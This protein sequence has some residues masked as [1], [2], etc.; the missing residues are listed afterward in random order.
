MPCTQAGMHTYHARSTGN[1][2]MDT[3]SK[4]V[5]QAT[6]CGRK[7]LRPTRGENKTQQTE[8]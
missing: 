7:Q 1:I 6:Y 3:G 2:Y 5:L 4:P 8:K